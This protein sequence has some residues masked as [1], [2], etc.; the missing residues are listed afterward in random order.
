MPDPK[1][2]SIGDLVHFIALP[3]E[4]SLPD[5]FVHRECRLFM[6]AMIRRTRPS[7]VVEIDEYGSPWIHARMR[8]R[9]KYHLHSWSIMESTGWRPVKRRTR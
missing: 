3:D 8:V 1:S 5:Y 7:R 2:L 6:K 4:W 9:G